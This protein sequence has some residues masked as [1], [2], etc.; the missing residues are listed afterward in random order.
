MAICNAAHP[1]PGSPHV[2]VELIGENPYT[3]CILNNVTTISSYY[4]L[5]LRRG[6]NF[7]KPD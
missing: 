6:C 4:Q 1:T 3:A 7:Y 2:L 5:Q